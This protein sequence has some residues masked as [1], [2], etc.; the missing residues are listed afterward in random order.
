M[1]LNGAVNDGDKVGKVWEMIGGTTAIR[2]HRRLGRP[3][4]DTN[5]HRPILVVVET[6]ADRDAILEKSRNLKER[7]APYDK[8]YVKKDTHPSV[9]L[10]WRRL[11]TAE[12]TE[13]NRP[14]NYGHVIRLDTRE[15]KLY[16]DDIVIDSW[17]PQPF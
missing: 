15:R 5:R 17:N 11:R 7:G 2:S 4:P 9:R 8:I 14:E 12:Q 3:N 16:R 13:K 6:K 1:D 10:E